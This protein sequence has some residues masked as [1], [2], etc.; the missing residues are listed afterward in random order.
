[1]KKFLSVFLRIA[2]SI[3]LVVFLFL[4]V[5]RQSL[6]ETIRTANKGLLFLAFAIFSLNYIFCILRWEMLLR[7]VK[8]HLPLRRVIISYAGGVFFNLFLPSVIGGDFVRSI[9]LATHTK[10]PREVI[11]TVFLD[12]L[13]GFVG[14]VILALLA[15]FFGW[16]LVQIKSVL[17]AVAIITGI[18]LAIILVLFNSFIYRLVNRLLHSPKA[19]KIRESIKNLHNEMHLFKH[20]KKV[21]VKNLILSI[22]V[23]S[24]VP[25]SFYVTALAFG[26]KT[27]PLYFFVFIPIIGAITLLPIS[28][29][30]LGLRDASTIFFFAQVGISKDFAFAMSLMNFFFLMGFGVLGGLIYVLTVHHRRIQ[31]HQPPGV[32]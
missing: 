24:V 1:M 6:F 26:L 19:G 23:Q 25:L 21:I 28:I 2:I 31:H 11:A 27:N 5:D 30:G 10:R 13:S 7:A 8:I 14:L 29:G 18:L 17:L 3:A 15:V 4:Q 22:I 12:R 16:K 9:D 20:H 32:S